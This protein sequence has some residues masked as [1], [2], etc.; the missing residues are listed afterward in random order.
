MTSVILDAGLIW[1][2]RAGL[3]ATDGV[4]TS[5]PSTDADNEILHDPEISFIW[6][7]DLFPFC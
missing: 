5:P 2:S 6:L 7:K 1:I 3:G 4:E